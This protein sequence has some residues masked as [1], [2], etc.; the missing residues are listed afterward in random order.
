MS[1]L[2]AAALA[3]LT[4]Y[5]PQYPHHCRMVRSR[6]D[7]LC[8][9]PVATAS[10]APYVFD[11]G[12]F[13]FAPL[14]G[15]GM[16]AECACTTVTGAR[17]EPIGFARASAAYCTK[18]PLSDGIDPGDM[19]MC[20]SDQ[21]LVTAGDDSGVPGMLMENA[22]NNSLLRSEEFDNAAWVGDAGVT[23]NV[24]QS[25]DGG[26]NADLI[27]D[28]SD[29]GMACKT[30]VVSTTLQRRSAFGCYLSA[31]SATSA[32]IAMRGVGNSAG[33]CSATTSG[34]DSAHYRR[35]QCGGTAAYGAGITAVAVDVCVGNGVDVM[36]DIAAWGCQLEQVNPATSGLAHNFLTS[37]MPTTS[38]TTN[39]LI[40]TTVLDAGIAAWPDAGCAGGTVVLEWTPSATIGTGPIVFS[41]SSGRELYLTTTTWRALDGTNTGTTVNGAT[42]YVARR[43]ASRWNA[44]DGGLTL[45][46]V[47][48]GTSTTGPFDGLMETSSFYVGYAPGL[49]T[50]NGVIKQVIYDNSLT[51]CQ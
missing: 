3:L 17:G 33:D 2:L 1:Q 30:Q 5:S 43:G 51:R 12:W 36:G 29:A 45:F 22:S 24:R 47:T 16:S 10:S 31:G 35:L 38:T 44:A 34:L 48:G 13:E 46:D 7:R 19:V 49:L 15:D 37:Y 28:T 39:R 20:L 6:F 50:P 4:G 9:P 27:A 26:L 41:G 25:P 23:A 18:G 14:T 42:A 11:G 40:P 8:P 32:T 21:P